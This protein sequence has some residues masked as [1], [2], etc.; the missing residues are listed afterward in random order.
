M[1]RTSIVIISYNTLEYTKLCI[2]GIRQLTPAGSYELI[3]VDNA[4][5]DGS[6]QWLRQQQ[7]VRLI[8]NQVNK[9][10]PAGCNQGMAEAEA[11]NDILLLNSDTVVTPRWLKNMQQALYSSE[12]IG[13]V[14]CVT[15]CC[16]NWQQIAAEYDNLDEMLLFA[17]K[18][19]IS[20]P[21]KWERRPKLVGFCYLIKNAAFCRV[22]FLDE[23]FTPGNYE[24]DDYSLRMTL[25]G[26]QLVLCRDTFI[27]HYGSASFKSAVDE[28]EREFREQQYV[29]LNVQ[30]KQKL[31]AKWQ[32]TDK[33]I[34]WDRVTDEVQEPA[35]TEARIMVV[36]C[37][38][39]MDLFYLQSKFPHARLIGIAENIREAALAG[40]SFEVYHCRDV[41]QDI[42]QCL[43]GEY[44]Y[45]LLCEKPSYYRDFDG[46]IRKLMAYLSPSGSIHVSD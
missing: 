32:V 18:H 5:R 25:A 3:V 2:E 24:D 35:D 8:E 44:D 39:G 6:V 40:R 19:N 10:F 22:G 42:F 26:Y 28:K 11:G 21:A 9:G 30:N 15:N 43:W 27:H 13:A 36:G 41:E 45:I 23:Q 33:Y 29:Q 7:D 4:S 12:N 20:N 16:S 46:Y 34:Y 14:S 31:L 17:D 37:H 1:N 38:A